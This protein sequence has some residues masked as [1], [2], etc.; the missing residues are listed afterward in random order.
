MGMM[1]HPVGSRQEG[2][3]MS[4]GIGGIIVGMGKGRPSYIVACEKHYQQE[5]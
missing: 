3:R 4:D 5:S 1:R 2:M